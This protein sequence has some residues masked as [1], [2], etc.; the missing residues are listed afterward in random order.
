MAN[1]VND[2]VYDTKLPPQLENPARRTTIAGFP[3]VV[4]MNGEYLG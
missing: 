4:Y 1:F 3:I 2:N